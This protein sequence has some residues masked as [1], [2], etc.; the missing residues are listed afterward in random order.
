MASELLGNPPRA[1]IDV[2]MRLEQRGAQ[3]SVPADPEEGCGTLA[4]RRGANPVYAPIEMAA[5]GLPNAR[6][7][8][9]G[10]EGCHALPRHWVRNWRRA[11]LA[12]IILLLF[13]FRLLFLFL[14]LFLFRLLFL[15]LF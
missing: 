7:C 1:A 9:I 11:G 4:H 12:A 6:I 2:G 10:L 15:F 8:V 5:I 14:C 3:E 13:L